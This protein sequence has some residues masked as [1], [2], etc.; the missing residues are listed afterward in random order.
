MGRGG[1]GGGGGRSSGG[2]GGRSSGGRMGGSG[3]GGRGGGGFRPS[4]GPAFGPGPGFGGY[5]PPRVGGFGWRRPVGPP[6]PPGPR[7]GGGGCLSS[8]L[9][10]SVVLVAVLF[11]IFSGM[12]QLI[13][14]RSFSGGD[15]TAST[16]KREPLDPTYVTETGY[17][18][19]ELG[20]IR[21]QTQLEKGMKAFYQETGVQPYLYLTDTVNGTTSPTA[22]D[23]DA[24]SNAL[25]DQLF[26]DE[27][28]LLVLFQEYNSSG[29]YNMWYVCGSQAK[30]VIDQEAVD[31]LFDYLDHYY[32]SDLSE[33]EMFSTAFSEAADR[34]MSVTRSP[35]V[36]VAVCAAVVIVLGLAYTWW[37]KA[38]QQKNREAEQTKKILETDLETFSQSEK[39][40][41]LSDLEDKYKE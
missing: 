29:N 19:D 40:K 11:M 32:Y 3:R 34:I 10:V 13:A 8:T 9:I 1:R 27:G 30:V 18:T 35:W 17:F 26:Q 33:E 37:K 2:G 38:K 20:W 39:D 7:R 28:H 41:T 22:D 12:G 16:V 24:Y 4:R 23:M 5:R 36:T 31:I 21:N 25:Y 6:P 15:I 14:G